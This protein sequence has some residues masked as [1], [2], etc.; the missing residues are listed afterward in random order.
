MSQPN[1]TMLEQIVDRITVFLPQN[2]STFIDLCPDILFE[3]FSFFSLDELIDSFSDLIPSL[4]KLLAQGHVRLFMMKQLDER[5]WTDFFPCLNPQQMITL[6]VRYQ[7]FNQTDFSS[8]VLLSSITLEDAAFN[9]PSSPFSLH[10]IQQLPRLRRF[11][12]RLPPTTHNEHDW[13]W[14]I[15]RLPTIKHVRIEATNRNDTIRPQRPVS[16]SPVACQSF[17]ITSLNVKLPF[18]WKSIF[19]LLSHFPV[20]RTFRAHLYRMRHPVN[21]LRLHIPKLTC[22]KTIRTLEL[23]GYFVHTSS[24]IT[25]FCSSIPNLT[26]CRLLSTSVTQDSLTEVLYSRESFFGR[27]LF[28]SCPHLNLVKIH[29]IISVEANEDVD[30][31]RTRN[32]I[33]A[34]N[35]DRFCRKYHFSLVHRSLSNGY[36]TLICDFHR[37]NKWESAIEVGCHQI[38]SPL[39]HIEAVNTSIELRGWSIGQRDRSNTYRYRWHLES[40]SAMMIDPLRPLRIVR[41]IFKH[42]RKKSSSHF[43]RH[44]VFLSGHLKI[45]Y[46]IRLSREAPSLFAVYNHQSEH[47]RESLFRWLD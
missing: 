37:E 39:H 33:R 44:K 23:I 1:K 7:R 8:Y 5:F 42:Y 6:N 13:L 36:V 38:W 45:K 3:L 26:D 32:L 16:I 14:Q 19:I 4:S 9:N 22:F 24:I 46:E 29:M 43:L 47:R 11:I 10:R 25:L 21:D 15:L 35:E 31:E 20:L 2:R 30:T 40:S 12:L 18:Q 17:T 28:Q 34:F 27:Q 41:E